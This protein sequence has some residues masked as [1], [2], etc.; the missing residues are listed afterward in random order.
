VIATVDQCTC[1]GAS[2]THNEINARQHAA[3]ALHAAGQ[4]CFAHEAAPVQSASSQDQGQQCPTL[5]D[6]HFQLC[7]A[8]DRSCVHQGKQAIGHCEVASR[9]TKTLLLMV[10]KPACNMRG[11]PQLQS[12]LQH[13]CS[14]YPFAGHWRRWWRWQCHQQDHRVGCT[15]KHRPTRA[16]Y[17]PVRVWLHAPGSQLPPQVQQLLWPL[18]LLLPGC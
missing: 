17:V 1:S 16:V 14:C 13:Q 9:D 4:P 5:S 12:P 15:G 7:T 8:G 2:G 10:S 18:C 6:R 11:Q 3:D